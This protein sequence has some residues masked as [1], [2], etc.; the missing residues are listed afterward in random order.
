MQKK[1]NEGRRHDRYDTEAKIHFIVPYDLTTKVNFQYKKPQPDPALN[2][3]F[4]GVTKNISA[5]GICF[6]SQFKPQRGDGLLIDLFLPNAEKP[7]P[8]EGEV[9]WSKAT[10]D[11]LSFYTGVQLVKVSGKPVEESIY[12][13][14]DHQVIWSAVLDQVLGNFALLHKK[15]YPNS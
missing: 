7:I 13:D 9:K 15:I 8:M 5:G 6:V 11:G 4:E 3:R 10:D 2:K 14:E 1:N 12:F